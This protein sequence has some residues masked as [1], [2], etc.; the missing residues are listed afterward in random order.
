MHT[1]VQNGI[2]KFTDCPIAPLQAS[3]DR[4]FGLWSII[5]RSTLRAGACCGRL[6]SAF[7]LTLDFWPT[8]GATR[9]R[10]VRGL[11]FNIGSLLM[12]C[13]F[14]RE[15]IESWGWRAFHDQI[16]SWSS[17]GKALKCLGFPP[18]ANSKMSSVD[19]WIGIWMCGQVLFM[20]PLWDLTSSRMC[21]FT[22]IQSPDD[23][24]CTKRFWSHELQISSLIFHFHSQQI[25][26][27]III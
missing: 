9:A 25:Q 7:T 2:T 21:I 23:I 20:S 8:R 18:T 22:S 14:L 11:A 10:P 27:G 16:I 24:L 13:I 15:R 4:L 12:V 19:F 1:P 5:F 6:T 17:F 3:T 26:S